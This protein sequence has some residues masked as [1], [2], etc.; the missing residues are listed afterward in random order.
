M[1][2]RAGRVPVVGITGTGGAGKSSLTDELIRRHLAAHPDQAVALF[3]V[4]P[5]KRRT[6]GAL[7]GDRIR[8]NAIHD[9]RCFLRSFATRGARGEL[10][11]AVSAAIALARVWGF[12]LVLVETSGIGQGDSAIAEISDISLYVMTSEFG[13]ATQLE[14][15]DMI[16]FAD[17]IVV[18]KFE[19]PGAE[20]ALRDVR[21]QYRRSRNEFT[22]PDAQLPVFGT[23]ASRFNDTGVNALFACLE[24]LLLCVRGGRPL[25]A[26][27]AGPAGEPR[28]TAQ[29]GTLIPRHRVGYLGEITRA[30]RA[31][32]AQA[33]RDAA[34]VRRCQNLAAAL[35]ELEAAADPGSRAAAGALR[36]HLEAARAD[37]RRGR[38]G[39]G[40]RAGTNWRPSSPATNWCSTSATGRCGP[41]R[42]PSP[43]RVRACRRW[44][45]RPSTMPATVCSSCG[46]KTC[47]A[48][49]RSRPASSR[50]SGP[51]RIRGASSRARARRPARTRASTISAVMTRPSGSARPSTA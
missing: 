23:V 49:S 6:G 51:T 34:L 50:S 12:D 42:T 4:D 41:P 28:A 14:K 33:V 15:I 8:M 27:L 47:R 48:P 40:G 39:G 46:G 25:D 18:N 1:A 5:S 35:G 2:I 24:R 21:R 22:R 36:R 16:D 45:C 26:G 44:R 31:H 29:V 17:V 30:V 11:A 20:D 9:P 19:R 13:A 37:G 10:S 38:A 32:R 43:W 3:A 7:L